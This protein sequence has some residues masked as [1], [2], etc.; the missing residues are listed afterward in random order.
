MKEIKINRDI[1][2]NII[3]DIVEA[4]I[5]EILGSQPNATETNLGLDSLDIYDIAFRVEKETHIA[6][7]VD[8]HSLIPY[9]MTPLEITIHLYNVAIKEK[10]KQDKLKEA[11]KKLER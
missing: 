9:S 8:N 1:N 2:I 6:G 11:R 3:Y 7:I 4:A 10:E 5:T